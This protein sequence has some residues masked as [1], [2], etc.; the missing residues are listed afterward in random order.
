[1]CLR[2]LRA[3]VWA[4]DKRKQLNRVTARLVPDT[5]LETVAVVAH[6]RLVVLGGDN[7]RL[8]EEVI[9]AGGKLRKGRFARFR[10]LSEMEVA[11]DAGLPDPAPE[12]V[13]ESIRKQWPNHRD[14]LF[15]ALEARMRDRTR[16]LEEKF[17]E[18]ADKEVADMTSVLEELERT[19]RDQL[20]ETRQLEFEGWS[21]PERE[22]FDRNMDS[23]RA[24]VERIPEEIQR[25]A[26]SI[27]GR[28]AGP[29]PRLFPVSVTY[30]VPEKIARE[31]EGRA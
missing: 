4:T 26:E 10:S 3:E 22:Q 12:S 7:H 18:R 29:T 15:Q 20:H 23:I 27:R 31:A 21:A 30:L 14:A 16:N 11:L 19:I 25:E 1:M 9:A 8:H 13:Q 6:G 28:F 24:R 2:L 17:E 5:A